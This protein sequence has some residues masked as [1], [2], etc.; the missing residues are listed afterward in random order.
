MYLSR[1]RFLAETD[2]L[3]MSLFVRVTIS[4]VSSWAILPV[5]VLASTPKTG[6]VILGELFFFWT[7]RLVVCCL[8]LVVRAWLTNVINFVL[9]L[10]PTDTVRFCFP[11]S[12]CLLMRA[13]SARVRSDLACRRLDSVS[14]RTPTI[15][16]SSISSSFRVPYSQFAARR[17]TS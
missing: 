15:I 8:L 16:Q 1:I 4:S 5:M 6:T 13:A 10:Y 11:A 12:A 7:Y 14:S 9:S 17:Y 2:R 3:E